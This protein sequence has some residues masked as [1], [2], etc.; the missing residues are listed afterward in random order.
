MAH[1]R[2]V[3]F[4]RWNMEEESSEDDVSYVHEDGNSDDDGLDELPVAPLGGRRPQ[5]AAAHRLPLPYHPTS[6]P[7]PPRPA[8]ARPAS[9]TP[10]RRPIL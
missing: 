4:R 3:G 8:S 2:G 5:T 6:T 7:L 1:R 10:L 9:A